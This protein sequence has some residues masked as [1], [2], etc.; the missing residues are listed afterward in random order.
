MNSERTPGQA[1]MPYLVG[2]LGAF[3]IVAGLVWLMQRYTQA[4]PLDAER[5]AERARNLVQL[6]AA[7]AES[8][9]TIG[10]IDPAKE[11]VRL[12]IADA[13]TL[14]EREWQDPATARSN[15]LA[16]AAL[17]AEPPPKPPEEPNPFD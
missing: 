12:R 13:M 3:L 10:W 15:L 7:E 4:P 8:L 2:I 6:R 14:V 11:I 1:G 9:N 5:A 17:A 16:R